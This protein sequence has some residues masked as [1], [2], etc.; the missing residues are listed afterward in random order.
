MRLSW[1]V[2]LCIILAVPAAAEERSPVDIKEWT[3]PWENSRPRDPYVESSESVWFVGQRGHYLANLNPAS[4]EFEKMD[5]EPGTGPHNLIVGSD[6]AVW[7][8]GN[9]KG[10]IGR[11]EPTSGS[12]H[13][14]PMSDPAA[15]DPHTLVFDADESH[16]FFTAQFS[17]YVGRLTLADESVDLIKVPTAQARPYGIVVAPDGTPWVALFGTNKLATIDRES[18]TLTEHPLP[19]A[20]A[21]PRRLGVTDDGRVWYVDYAGGYLGVY[22]P[23]D[24]SVTEWALPAGTD[25]RPYG[26]AVDSKNRIWVVQTG[27][28]PNTFVGFDPA[29]EAFFSVTPI[30][31]GA[32]TV[33]HMDYHKASDT[34]WFGTDANTVGRA[35]VE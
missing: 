17:N 8:A 18:M 6:G 23:G 29:S 22:R 9:L 24:K 32:G 15:K 35:A 10:Y 12:I 33:R 1:I 14:I 11:Y 28:A 27:P 34:I 3:V 26:M 21:R 13:K 30:P 2:S 19:R 5:L 16:I 7:F 20:E 4:G 31:S 25:S